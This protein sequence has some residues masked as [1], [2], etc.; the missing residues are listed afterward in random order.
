MHVPTHLAISWL[1]AH[2]LAERRDRRLVAWAGVAPDIDALSLLAGP[3]GI[4]HYHHILTHNLVSAIVVTFLFTAFARDR[5][6][7]AILALTTFHL[8][9]L[10]DLLGAGRDW[11]IVYLWPFSRYEYYTPYGWPLASWENVTITFVALALIAWVGIVR[12]C[13]FVETF[14]P[15]KAGAA[16]VEVLRRRFAPHRAQ[17]PPAS[18]ND[19]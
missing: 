8:H 12:G 9:L 3:E 19:P 16:V 4:R 13:T 15:A 14:A 7:V 17:T 2:G 10:C 6:K 1:V 18:P 5:L 11:P